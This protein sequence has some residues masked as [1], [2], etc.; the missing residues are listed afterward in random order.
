MSRESSNEAFEDWL[1]AA[2]QKG[3]PV[4]FNAKA[5]WQA[6]R[7]AA[8]EEAARLFD[9]SP[10]ADRFNSDIADMIRQLA[11]EST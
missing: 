7:A 1:H 5:A 10:H 8:L 4:H 3:H 9:D 2:S 6:S 11:K